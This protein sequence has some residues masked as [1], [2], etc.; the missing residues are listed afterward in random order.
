MIFFNFFYSHVAIKKK[1]GLCFHAK[2]ATSRMC[3]CTNGKLWLFDRRAFVRASP[4]SDRPFVCQ[5]SSFDGWN[6]SVGSQWNMLLFYFVFLLFETRFCNTSYFVLIGI[7]TKHTLLSLNLSCCWL[8]Y[9]IHP[10]DNCEKFSSCCVAPMYWK[11]LLMRSVRKLWLAFFFVFLIGCP[12][13]VACVSR[14]HKWSTE[15]Y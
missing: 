6:S 2:L 11:L 15:R 10:I 7:N 13:F 12:V 3:I 5:M 8:M 14:R 1:K 4:F 9:P